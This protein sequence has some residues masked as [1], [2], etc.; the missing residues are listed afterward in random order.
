L[1]D[2]GLTRTAVVFTVAGTQIRNFLHYRRCQMRRIE[3]NVEKRPG[4]GKSTNER[5]AVKLE[6]GQ[7]IISKPRWRDVAFARN[8]E[9]WE[10][11]IS[12]NTW[13]RCDELKIFQRDACLTLE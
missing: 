11:Q 9:R 8:A 5:G 10:G 13:L 4:S 12:G 2:D 7:E 1:N 6:D 3:R